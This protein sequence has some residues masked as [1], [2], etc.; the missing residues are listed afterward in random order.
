M[1]T[2]SVACYEK[3]LLFTHQFL[4][5][6]QRIHFHFR[7]IFNMSTV[8]PAHR[9]SF[10]DEL[11]QLYDVIYKTSYILH[12]IHVV[13]KVRHKT[14]AC[15]PALVTCFCLSLSKNAIILVIFVERKCVI[16]LFGS[17]R[18]NPLPHMQMKG[19]INSA[20]NTDMMST[21]W[22][23]RDTIIWLSRKHC[24]KRRNCS[25]RAISPFATMFSKAVCYWC[26]KMKIYGVKA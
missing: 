10:C 1:G 5:A 23:N 20:A 8:W 11:C 2:R 7:N 13:G 18:V 16:D 26:V 19:S 6:I 15:R 9:R 14:N 25:L 22:T 21:T 3:L 24:G 4:H 12:H 17:L